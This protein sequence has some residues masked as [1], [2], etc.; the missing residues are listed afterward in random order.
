MESV[1]P[2]QSTASMQPDTIAAPLDAARYA[3]V[4]TAVLAGAVMPGLRSLYRHCGASQG[5]AKRYLTAMEQAGNIRRAG[6]GL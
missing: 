3:A 2:M 5:V 1:S 4:R 6:Q